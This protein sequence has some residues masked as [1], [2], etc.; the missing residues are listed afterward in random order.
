[1]TTVFN[2]NVV[3][4]LNQ[5][6]F[7][8]EAPNVVRYETVQNPVFEQL[9]EKQLSFFWRPEEVDLTKD[10]L[11]FAKMSRV[12]QRIF[13]ENLKYQ[14]LLDSV[15]GRGPNLAFLPIVSDVALETWIETWSFSETIHSRSYTHI[16]RNVYSDPSAIFDQIM[17]S[18]EIMNR[19]SAVTK[20]YDRLIADVIE[21]QSRPSA[22]SM[23]RAKESLYLCLHAVNALEAIR[24]YDSFACTFSFGE[25]GLMEGSSKIMRL[26]ARDEQLHLKGTQTML[27]MMQSGKDC[28]EMAKIAVRMREQA[29]NIF[30]EVAAQ[31][32][33]WAKHLT[34]DGSIPMITEQSLTEYIDYVTDTRMRAV[35]LDSPFEKTKH[36]LPWM[37]K[38]LNS[39]SVQVAAQEAEIS[40]YLVGQMDSSI[41]DEF[42][43]SLDV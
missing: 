20:Y 8:G 32:K 43:K 25:R 5:P 13:T 21:Y 12:E 30:L 28:P 36:P 38:W 40:S 26:I 10:A 18:P 24:F 9:T 17:L 22:F 7:F 4:H 11:D 14:S 39:D 34:K 41:S 31:E 3:D 27:R 42:L 33:E 19:A 15:Q 37:R 2:S 29:N 16:I 35:D 6:M 23:S 1:M